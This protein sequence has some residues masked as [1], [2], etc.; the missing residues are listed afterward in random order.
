[1]DREDDDYEYDF[2]EIENDEELLTKLLIEEN[3]I[4]SSKRV[5]RTH[6]KSNPFANLTHQDEV[7]TKRTAQD[8][9]PNAYMVLD[10]ESALKK[11]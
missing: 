4:K 7:E 10:Q 9:K 6:P 1:M 5:H 2:Q 11:I 3:A 8:Q